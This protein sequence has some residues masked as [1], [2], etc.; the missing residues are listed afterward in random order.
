MYKLILVSF[1]A[2]TLIAC[3]NKGALYLPEQEQT[4]ETAVPINKE[5]I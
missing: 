4:I 3:G 5:V 2:S 1:F